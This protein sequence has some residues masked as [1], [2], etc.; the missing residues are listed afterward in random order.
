MWWCPLGIWGGGRKERL[1]DWRWYLK[2]ILVCIYSN[3]HID[4]MFIQV[5]FKG[6]IEDYISTFS[7]AGFQKRYIVVIPKL[8]K[9]LY[10]LIQ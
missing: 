7:T 10:K 8:M 5:C 1:G 2:Q 6:D 9:H 4:L 3:Y